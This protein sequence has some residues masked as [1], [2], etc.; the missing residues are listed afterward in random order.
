MNIIKTISIPGQLIS[1]KNNMQAIRLGP[2]ASIGHKKVWRVYEKHALKYLKKIEPIPAHHFAQGAIY[3][4]VWH[5]RR[6][7]RAFDHNNLVQGICD[8]LQGDLRCKDK[9]LRHKIIPEDDMR[10]LIP[11]HESPYAGWS[12]DKKNPRTVVIFTEDVDFMNQHFEQV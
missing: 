3:M 7:K 11:V 8:V 5:H 12:I 4:H 2:R 10:H 1:K 6:D 9:S